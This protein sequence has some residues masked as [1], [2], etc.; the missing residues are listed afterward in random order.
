MPFDPKT[1]ALYPTH[2]GVYLMK[3]HGGLV[4]YVGKAKNLRLRLKQYFVSSG[5]G[6]EMIP[7][8]IPQVETIETISVNSEKEAL[9]LESHLIKKHKPKYNA[10]LKDDKSYVALKINVKHPWPLLSLERYRGK[11][12]AEGVYFGPYA[13]AGAARRTLDLLHRLFPLRQCSDAEFSRRSRPCILYDMKR[14]IAPCVL[15]CSQEEYQVQVNRTIKFLRGQNKEIV[16][17]MYKEMET[18]AEKLEFEKAAKILDTIRYIEKT[19]EPQYVDSVSGKDA[20]ALGVYRQGEDVMLCQLQFREGRLTASQSFNFTKI[21]ED[22]AELLTS[23]MLQH[24]QDKDFLPHEILLPIEIE[25]EASL[26]ELL[27]ENRARKTQ[28]YSPKRGSKSVLIEMA[29]ANAEASFKKE[30][31]EQ[32]LR[33]NILLAMQEQFHLTNYPKKIECI[34]NSHIAGTEHVSTVIAFSEGKKDPKNYR[35]YKLKQVGPADDYGA[36]REV[37]SR[38]YGKAKDENTLPDLLIVDGGKGHLNLALKVLAELDIVSV[39]VIGIAKEQGRH[40]RGLTSEQVFL[41]NVKDPLILKVTSP[42]LFMVQQIRDEAH[43][44]VIKFHR[45]R[46][47]KRTIKSALDD[48]P[49]IGPTKKRAL[50]KHFGSVKKMKEASDEEFKKVKGITPHN[51]EQLRQFLKMET[52]HGDDAQ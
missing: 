26:T 48:V 12:K 45:K 17:E 3:N 46:M 24:Y 10:L 2:P 28:I 30:K 27:S 20:D 39:N 36:M 34:D 23:F 8:L 41:P 16:Q 38:R 9:L 50:L 25:D 11:P 31:D 18:Y 6:R 22:D 29:Q 43:R 37:L 32:T 47:Q 42:V 40:D 35:T 7:F 13:H 21:A 5:D 51:I 19:V 15:K 33:E 52:K 14:C 44:F 49:G 4:L 1:L